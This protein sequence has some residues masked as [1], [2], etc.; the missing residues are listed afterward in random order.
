MLSAQPPSLPTF[1]H[2][3]ND[4]IILVEMKVNVVLT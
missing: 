3:S 1:N 2:C 4:T